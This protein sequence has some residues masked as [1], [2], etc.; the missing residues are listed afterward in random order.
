MHSGRGTQTGR[1][2]RL[3]L[4]GA[5][6]LVA[7]AAWLPRGLDGILGRDLGVYAY[8]GERL[9]SAG[10]WPYDAVLN[11]AGPL[12]H[13]L[14]GL[15]A[16]AGEPLGAD[17]IASM[18]VAYLACAVA[19]VAL[20]ALVARRTFGSAVAAVAAAA[21]FLTFDEFG[22]LATW[23]PREKTVMVLLVLAS[24]A[25]SAARRWV[26]A[27]VLV[28]AATLTWQPAFVAAFPAVVAGALVDREGA[29]SRRALARRVGLVV[30]GG[31]GTA[32]LVLAAYAVTGRLQR[33]LD[34]FVLINARWTEQPS[35]VG[36]LGEAVDTTVAGYGVGAVVA[37]VG[38]V[39][40]L[41]AGA[42]VLADRSRRGRR[43]AAV[44]AAAV[45]T[46]GAVLWS[47][48]AYQ[49]APDLFVV[50]PGAALGVAGLASALASRLASRLADRPRAAL[51]VPA[52]GAALLVAGA[53]VGLA[54]AVADRGGPAG[55]GLD[56]QRAVVAELQGVVGDDARVV[57]LDAPDLTVL[58]GA[59][60]PVRVMLTT[61]G[62]TDYVEDTWPGGT[63]G[64]ADD[65]AATD[66]DVVA[67]RDTVD[68]E[69][70]LAPLVAGRTEVGRG[71]GWR[72]WVT[73]DVPERDL[74]R[75]RGYFV[76]AAWRTEED[77]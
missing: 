40:S 61:N 60:S 64:F 32:A 54:G 69:S 20:A 44:V 8:A 55:R 33:F 25:A 29:P 62:L 57:T 2:R 27:G 76:T 12:G 38:V 52:L 26:L 13:L 37:L 28:A 51:A 59:V 72:I 10:A 42:R 73:D 43:D 17:P 4:P 77:E 22:A 24:L 56:E 31:A 46:L 58:W 19:T 6:A 5:L 21:A 53:G 50:L 14:P 47:L 75:L 74:R 70:W 65:L 67:L 66:P 71:A 18:R 23:G 36:R 34:C 7:L 11:R 45:A 41:V 39:A 35:P 16:L 9:A 30:A 3:L 49:G 68:D 48:R 63:E 1:A 15:A